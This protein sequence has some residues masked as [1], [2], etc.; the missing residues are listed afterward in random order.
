MISGFRLDVCYSGRRL[1]VINRRFGT[2]C[3][4]I[5]L[6][7]PQKRE[8]HK[9]SDFRLLSCLVQQM[10]LVTLKWQNI[11]QQRTFGTLF[12]LTAATNV[13]GKSRAGVYFCIPR[14]VYDVPSSHW[15]ETCGLKPDFYQNCSTCIQLSYEGALL[16]LHAFTQPT[17]CLSVC[18]FVRK[19]FS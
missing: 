16:I 4:P 3:R 14:A 15:S 12:V 6:L 5:R 13:H 19:L 17:V 9:Q 18:L 10:H 8:D 7:T 2:S 11:W 1:V